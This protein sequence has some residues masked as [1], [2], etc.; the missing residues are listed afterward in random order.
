MSR[1]FLG[2]GT[3]SGLTTTGNKIGGTAGYQAKE[4]LEGIARTTPGDVYAFGGLILAVGSFLLHLCFTCQRSVVT[5]S[6]RL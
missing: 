5:S 6:D 1:I 3:V 2:L 4:L